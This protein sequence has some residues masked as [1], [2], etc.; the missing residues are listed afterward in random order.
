M[1]RKHQASDQ[2]KTD[3]QAKMQISRAINIPCMDIAHLDGLNQ[4]EVLACSGKTLQSVNSEDC[5]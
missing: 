3:I 1:T 4:G 5:I 2:L